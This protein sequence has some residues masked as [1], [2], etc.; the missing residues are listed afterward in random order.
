MKKVE[1]C[2]SVMPQALSTGDR[3]HSQVG[4]NAVCTNKEEGGVKK[5]EECLSLMPQTL[6]TG[7]RHHSQVGN[8]ALCTNQ[9]VM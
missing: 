7:D 2:L 8:N 5:V 6:S 9:E 1:E 4:N 3:R